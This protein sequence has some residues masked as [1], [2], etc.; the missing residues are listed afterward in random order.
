MVLFCKMSGV[1]EGEVFHFWPRISA[2]A[3]ESGAEAN[4]FD[5]RI[6]DETVFQE[7]AGLFAS[8]EDTDT[9]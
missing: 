1:K 5:N 6:P 9:R 4:K 7:Y 2:L 8:R 3:E